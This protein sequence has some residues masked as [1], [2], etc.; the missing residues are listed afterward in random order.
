[1][2]TVTRLTTIAALLLSLGANAQMPEWS[3]VQ[4]EVWGVVSASW[5]DDVAENGKWPGDYTH[6]NY[7]TIGAD[8]VVPRMRDDA[9]RWSKF[10]DES[11]QTLIYSITPMA[12]QIAGNTAVV[13]YSAET[14]TENKDGKRTRSVSTIVETL[15]KQGRE[16]K[17]LAGTNFE[18]D[19]SE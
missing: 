5:E 8:A 17:F 2:N 10:G 15:V 9:I 3:D 11:N 12:I 7:A 19:V 6:E 13:F 4:T 16:W 14:V 18:P 1:M